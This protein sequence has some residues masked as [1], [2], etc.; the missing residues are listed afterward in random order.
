MNLTKS[1][2]IGAISYASYA[3][4]AVAKIIAESAEE[5]YAN[6]LNTATTGAL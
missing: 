5:K 6:G 3:Q 4:A 2:F 1:L